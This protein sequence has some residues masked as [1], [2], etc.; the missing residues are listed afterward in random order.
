MDLESI[1]AMMGTY[2]ERKVA[3]FESDGLV[4]DTAA[5]PDSE[6][7]YETAVL[8]PE[9]NMGKWVVVEGYDTKEDAQI[10]HDHWVATMTTEPLPTKLVDCANSEISQLIKSTGGQMEFPRKRE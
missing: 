10:G 4:V 8:H 3:R 5:V 7:P 1:L 6:H 2:A 9:Y